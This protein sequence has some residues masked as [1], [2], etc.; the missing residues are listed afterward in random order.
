MRGAEPEF[1][2]RTEQEALKITRS[3]DE[4]RGDGHDGKV[5]DGVHRVM[6]G[7]VPTIY[8]FALDRMTRI[9]LLAL[10]R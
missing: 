6:V 7:L 1:V 2:T 10:P 9:S 4:D 5:G 8:V 3:V